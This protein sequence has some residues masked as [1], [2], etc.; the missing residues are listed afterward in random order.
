MKRE[1]IYEGKILSLYKLENGYEIIKHQAAV[2]VLVLDGERV[3]GVR[4]QR[5]AI[6]GE[7]WEIPA[8]LVDEG[9]APLEAA[10]RELAEEVQLQGELRLITQAYT[11]PGYCDE[12]I[13]IYEASGLSPSEGEPE[14]EEDLALEWR[15]LKE[16]WQAVREGR[17]Q[18]SAPTALA[19]AYALGRS[20]KL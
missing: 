19:L 14:E 2:C 16:T 17:L 5:P 1:T 4:Q 8:G 3:L 6:N 10:R 18:T 13:F 7:T 12:K 15:D 20:G 9:E 11:S